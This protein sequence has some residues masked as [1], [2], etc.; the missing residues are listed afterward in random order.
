[1]KRR[2]A[3][4]LCMAA[5]AVLWGCAGSAGT[6][7]E[8][9]AALYDRGMEVVSLMAEMAGSQEYIGYA[10]GDGEIEEALQEMAAGDYTA[11]EAVYSISAPGGSLLEAIGLGNGDG[12][13]EELQE[14]LRQRML[15]ALV[16]Q[17]NGMDSVV[18]LA[19][20]NVC[21]ASCTFVDSS[22]EEDVLYLYIFPDTAPAAVAFT[23][24]EDGAVYASGSLLLNDSFPCG[25]GEEIQEFFG[26]LGMEIEAEAVPIPSV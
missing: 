18:S 14:F 13:S 24:G 21:A 1:M 7:G 16:S 5:A 9:E 20:A 19:A 4:I 6:G 26:R 15:A 8:T 10:T 2:A 25:S 23:A 22:L 11:P 3:A 12:M 17:I